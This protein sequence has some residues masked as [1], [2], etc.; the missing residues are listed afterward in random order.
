MTRLRRSRVRARASPV[1]VAEPERRSGRLM[2]FDRFG[3]F[4]GF[5]L[6]TS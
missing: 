2:L 3:D 4:E 1:G 5:A 6:D